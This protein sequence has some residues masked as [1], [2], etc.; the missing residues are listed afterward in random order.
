MRPS[1]RGRR[2]GLGGGLNGTWGG[3]VSEAVRKMEVVW[4]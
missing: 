2:I 4:G 3:F 1:R